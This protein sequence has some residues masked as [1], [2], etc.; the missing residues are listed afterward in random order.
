MSDDPRTSFEYFA[1]RGN[2]F[3]RSNG[4]NEYQME[5]KVYNFNRLSDTGAS[6]VLSLTED[7]LAFFEPFYFDLNLA[8]L[9]DSTTKREKYFTAGRIYFEVGTLKRYQYK[10]IFN[11]ISNRYV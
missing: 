5:L 7:Q 10:N 9:Y 8:V 2:E 11:N 1:R 4:L 3:A 6:V